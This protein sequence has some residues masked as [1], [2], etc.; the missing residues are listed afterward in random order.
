VERRF[1]E[2][3]LQAVEI[4]Y[5]NERV[6]ADAV[7]AKKTQELAAQAAQAQEAYANEHQSLVDY[8]N[9]NPVGAV[10]LCEPS[11]AV[12]G[13]NSSRTKPRTQGTAASPGDVQQ[14]PPGDNSVRA[15]P[16]PDIGQLLS[17]LANKAD[18]VT[19]KA[20]ESES[21]KTGAPR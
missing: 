6:A 1:A 2:V 13:S 11:G 7:A 18:D 5:T 17:I 16:G 9:L 21:T 20:R 19:A 14:V 8:V 12:S 10:R 15:I 3:R 4:K